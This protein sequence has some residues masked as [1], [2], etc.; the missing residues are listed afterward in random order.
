MFCALVWSGR[1][2]V[3]SEGKR[4]SY[5]EA[6]VLGLLQGVTE[7]LPVSSSGHLAVGHLLFGER[8]ASSTAFDVLVHGATLLVIFGVFGRLLVSLARENR[9]LLLILLV[10]SIPTALIGLIWRHEM[11]SLA[12]HPLAL[13]WCFC[14]TGSFLWKV[15]REE[16]SAADGAGEGMPAAAA[17][18]VRWGDALV[19]GLAQ[20]LAIAPGCSRSGLTISAGRL[21]GVSAE[22]AV[23]F[24]FLLGAPAIVGALAIESSQIGQ[25]AAVSPGPLAAGFAAALVSGIAAMSLLKHVAKRGLLPRFAPYCFLMAGLC[26]LLAATR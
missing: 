9:R 15:G 21:C 18:H 16:G 6:I 2:S 3:F 24:S 10:A 22:Q 13:A 4:V 8:T 11:E 5:W 26:V 14:I 25:L 1:G 7:F 23:A 12:S 20:A 19:I 17:W